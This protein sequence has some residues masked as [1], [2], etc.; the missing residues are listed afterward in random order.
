MKSIY[1]TTLGLLLLFSSLAA[2]YPGGTFCAL[3]KSSD[4]N[5]F[6]TKARE[7]IRDRFGPPLA[8]PTIVNFQTAEDN[9]PF[10]FNPYG[11]THFLPW[12]TCVVFGPKGQSVDVVAHELMH[13]ELVERVGY[14]QR[15][16]H[17][18]TWFDEGLAMQVD[19]RVRYRNFPNLL[20]HD[21]TMRLDSAAEFYVSDP[22]SLTQHYA[23]VRHTMTELLRDPHVVF[24]HLGTFSS[25]DSLW[26]SISHDESER[27]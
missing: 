2:A 24:N 18:P 21:D 13:A 7:R 26:Q 27:L 23:S 1:L 15:L 11:S 10:T 17:I 20:S 22:D 6:V 16:M 9:W 12:K 8:N 3:Q 19:D 14:W 5:P 25:F 4:N